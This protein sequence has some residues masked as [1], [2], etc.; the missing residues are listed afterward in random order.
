MTDLDEYQLLAEKDELFQENKKLKLA[1]EM[2]S[3]SMFLTFPE[4]DR[5]RIAGKLR[6][7]YLDKV[8]EG[9]E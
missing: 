1:F 4:K 8:G 6:E 9:M 7:Y 3:E 5:K 2:M